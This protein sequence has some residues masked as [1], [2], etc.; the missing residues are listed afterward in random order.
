MNF[1]DVEYILAA[2]ETGSFALASQK[3]H[4][5]QPSLSIQVK[6]VEDEL[7]TPLFIRRKNGVALTEFGANVIADFKAILDTEDLIRKKALTSLDSKSPIKLGAI[8]TV[9]PFI[10]PHLADL[11]G[12]EFHE[13]VTA[14]LIKDLLDDR[15]DAAI[16]ALP[17]KIPQL[18]SRQL[19]R[20]P[21]YFAYSSDRSWKGEIDAGTLSLPQGIKFI[22]LP[23]EH[24]LSEQTINLC[25][26]ENENSDR[27]FRATSLETIRHMVAGSDNVT[28]MPALAR[29]SND[30]L[31]YQALPANFS[32]K[33]GIVF[34]SKHGNIEDIDAVSASIKNMEIIKNLN[35]LP[36][37]DP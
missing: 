34:K 36:T 25:K 15:I 6:K 24:C 3:C 30:G 14:S 7:G 23:D 11:E 10:F 20:E 32:R 33:I 17:I 31:Y 27:T 5:S 12:I 18:V 26:L 8:A 35:S 21:L 16:L 13:S 4:V 28:L 2:A 9:G 1:R 29:R 19:Y 37:P 22:L